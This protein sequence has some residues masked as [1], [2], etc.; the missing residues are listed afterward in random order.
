MK[1][2]LKTNTYFITPRVSFDEEENVKLKFIKPKFN[3]F[4]A[5]LINRL[6]Q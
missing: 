4:K 5:E 2:I 1:I 6:C 3:T